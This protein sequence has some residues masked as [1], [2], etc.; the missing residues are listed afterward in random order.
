MR[1]L[2]TDTLTPDT[3]IL[4]LSSTRVAC[5]LLLQRY[6]IALIVLHIRFTFASMALSFVAVFGLFASQALAQCRAY[7]KD[8]Q[9][10]GIYFQNASSTEQFTFV[11]Y[12]E[13]CQQ[14]F[15]SNI[16]ID[17]AAEEYFCTKTPLTPDD[18]DQ[19]STC[20]ITK[21]NLYSGDWSII[22]SSNNGKGDPV[23]YERDFSLVVGVPTTFTYYP[24]VTV[25]STK[26][27]TSTKSVTTTT[28][29]TTTS[30]SSVTSPSVTIKPTVTVSQQGNLRLS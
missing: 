12:F 18:T 22:V 14:D 10:G 19:Q 7:G 11:Q 23:A 17:P 24:T 1:V 25:T 3:R 26:T 27:P 2:R 13:G 4:A 21:N 30:T 28:K 9:N 5:E 8:F 20:P 15:A 6:A 16:L 29:A